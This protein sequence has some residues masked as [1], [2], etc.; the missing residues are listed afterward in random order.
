[1]D[2]QLGPNYDKEPTFT[3]FFNHYSVNSTLA[4]LLEVG[5]PTQHEL[6][7]TTT[8]NNSND[9][10]LVL[11][12]A[13]TAQLQDQTPVGGL[14]PFPPLPNYASA[15]LPSCAHYADDLDSPSTSP[16]QRAKPELANADWTHTATTTAPVCELAESTDDTP[17]L[18][19]HGI[20]SYAKPATA[21]T[22]NDGLLT[23]T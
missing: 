21:S 17:P 19:N 4:K 11:T 23:P 10:P 1:M 3:T 8:S 7:K 18:S 2:Y 6:W 12:F 22:P 15:T 13:A 9:F 14:P 5:K 16:T 20:K